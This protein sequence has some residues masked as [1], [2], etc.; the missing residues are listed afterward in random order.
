MIFG[1][2]SLLEAITA[3]VSLAQ[4]DVVLTGTP[5]GVGRVVAGDVMRAR[6]SVASTGEQLDEFTVNVARRA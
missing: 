3:D 5:E 4:G 1:V 6:L 2:P